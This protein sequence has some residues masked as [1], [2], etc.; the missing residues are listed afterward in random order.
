MEVA[1]ER[2]A[3]ILKELK[4]IENQ[5]MEAA[6]LARGLVRFYVGFVLLAFAV[7]ASFGVFH[8]IYGI[9]RYLRS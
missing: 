8:I 2:I 4:R 6:R 7:L 5:L 3:M 1:T 9:I